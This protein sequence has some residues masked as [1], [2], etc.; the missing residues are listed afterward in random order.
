M[1]PAGPIGAPVDALDAQLN[2]VTATQ[3]VAATSF[4]PDQPTGPPEGTDAC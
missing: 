4:K 2:G 1:G 3:C